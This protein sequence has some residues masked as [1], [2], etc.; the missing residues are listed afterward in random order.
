MRKSRDG[1]VW[2]SWIPSEWLSQSTLLSGVSRYGSR[3]EQWLSMA[4]SIESYAVA[5]G[6]VGACACAVQMSWN[7][8]FVQYWFSWFRR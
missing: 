5:I 6:V 8:W 7:S 1:F 3:F 2:G 4:D